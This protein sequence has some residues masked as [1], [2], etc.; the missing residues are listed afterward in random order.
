MK[1]LMP[2]LLIGCILLLLAGCLNFGPK[3]N[4]PAGKACGSRGMTVCPAGQ[5]CKFELEAQ[6]GVTDMPGICTPIPTD[7][8]NEYYQMCGCDDKTYLNA[9]AAA[10][11]RVSVK[12]IGE[13]KKI[14]GGLTKTPCPDGQLCIDDPQDDCNP[15]SGPDCP[16]ICSKD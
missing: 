4:P 5:Y 6:C 15:A 10:S 16:G 13:C 8:T 9:C 1:N 3:P 12:R 14:C 2:V 11:A 7:C